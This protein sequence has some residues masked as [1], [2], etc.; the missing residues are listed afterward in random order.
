MGFS[1]PIFFNLIVPTRNRAD[2]LYFCLQ[3][4][5]SQ[6]YP[7]FRVIVSDN[8]STDD[9]QEMVLGFK[10]NRLHYVS[11]GRSLSMRENWEFALTHVDGGWIT[12]IG[13]DDGLIPNALARVAEVIRHTNVSAVT[14]SWCRYTWPSDDLVHAEKLILPLT[15]GVEIRKS[16]IWRR[17]V[18]SGIWRYIEL[19]YI[20]T[21]G[22]V[23]YSVIKKALAVRPKFFNSMTPDVYSAIAVSFL[24]SEYAYMRDP[25]ALRGTSSHSTGASAFRGSENDAPKQDF[26]A[27]NAGTLHSL[28]QDDN[29]PISTHFFVYECYLQAAFLL[30]E[31]TPSMPAV[32]LHRQLRI[33]TALSKKSDR[34]SVRDYCTRVLRR[35]TQK[36]STTIAG[37][38]MSLLVR[39]MFFFIE[40]KR[41]LN[42][43]LIDTSSVGV[44]DVYAA[45]IMARGIHW[46]E[47]N[48][49][50]RRIRRILATARSY[51]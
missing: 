36:D 27:Q 18:M 10:D 40:I 43:M 20:Y 19:P 14:S 5:L 47:G 28:L 21:G 1:D 49:A 34:Q 15:R 11:T 35:T 8:C 12:F 41:V 38:L 48:R 23:D 29:F 31:Q 7:H 30:S 44:R 3:S 25:I 42:S 6:N 22:F 13:D 33:V 51:Y 9:T 39:P 24:V 45:G 37:R 46:H 16:D 50:F 17:R 4:L 2:T 32:D 26:M